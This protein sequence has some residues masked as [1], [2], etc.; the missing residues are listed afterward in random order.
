[1]VAQIR[2]AFRGASTP[3][4]TQTAHLR[5]YKSWVELEYRSWARIE[6]TADR[7]SGSVE[8][9]EPTRSAFMGWNQHLQNFVDS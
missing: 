2:S 5:R 1:V 7:K 8:E 9:Q 3:S 6:E 4:H